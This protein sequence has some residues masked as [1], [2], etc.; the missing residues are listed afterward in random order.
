MNNLSRKVMDL[1]GYVQEAANA[2]VPLSSQDLQDVL[3]FK[4]ELE[5][6]TNALND[7]TVG[8]TNSGPPSVPTSSATVPS[9]PSTSTPAAPSVLGKHHRTQDGRLMSASPEKK[10]PRQESYSWI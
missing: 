9:K 1:R 4:V 6:L 8:A 2:A 5:L 7:L 3:S 10:R